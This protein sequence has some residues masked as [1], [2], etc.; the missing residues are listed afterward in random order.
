[1]RSNRSRPHR[2]VGE[3]LPEGLAR[4]RRQPYA[5]EHE[6]YHDGVAR[7]PEQQGGET[8]ADRTPVERM[9]GKKRPGRR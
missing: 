6:D 2:D 7:P 5:A 3:S 1:M 4:D 9:L 8:P